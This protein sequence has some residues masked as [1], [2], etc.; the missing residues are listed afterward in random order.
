MLA[1]GNPFSPA[2]LP[3]NPLLP[4]GVAFA[5]AAAGAPT[6]FNPHGLAGFA[7]SPGVLQSHPA[8]NGMMASGPASPINPTPPRIGNDVG[9]V[10]TPPLANGI[11]R[12]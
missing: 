9:P 12:P 1:T 7:T 5:A 6:H 10:T 8:A 4:A 11:T 3:Q 2:G